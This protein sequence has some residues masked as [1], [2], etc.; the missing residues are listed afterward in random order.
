MCFF[1]TWIA[2]STISPLIYCPFHWNFL[3]LSYWV[4]DQYPGLLKKK[5]FFSSLTSIGLLTLWG[6][7]TCSFVTI[8]LKDLIHTWLISS[9][10]IF[11]W[12]NKLSQAPFLMYLANIHKMVFEFF[13]NAFF[14]KLS[15]RKMNWLIACPLIWLLCN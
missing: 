11:S 14:P 13:S 7:L 3:L 6:K 8:Y 15:P 9:M 2:T 12:K 10:T 1:I 5:A 4:K